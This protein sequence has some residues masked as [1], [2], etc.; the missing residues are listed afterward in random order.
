MKLLIKSKFFSTCLGVLAVF[1]GIGFILPLSNFSVYMT[2]NIYSKHDY[3]TMHYGFFISLIFTFAN[4]ISVTLG[5]YL[6]NLIGFYKTTTVGF[7]IAFI[8]NT[9][10]IFQQDIWFCYC[11]TLIVGTGAGVATSLLGKNVTLYLP[12]KKG[13]VSGIFGIGIMIISA[14]Y[15][16]SGEKLINFE[17]YTLEEDESFYPKRIAKNTYKYFLIGEF[18]I[19]IGLIFALLLLYEYKPEEVFDQKLEGE[20]QI[21]QEEKENVTKEEAKEEIK[22]EAKEEKKEEIKEETKEETEEERQLKMKIIKQKLKRVLKT[23]RFWKISL[24]SFFINISISFMVTTGRTFGALIGING[25]ALQF[26]GMAQV[27][28]TLII[29][30][31]L[32]ILVDKKGGLII[33]RITAIISILPPIFLAFFMQNTAIFI[34][35]FVFDVLVLVGVMVCFGP[36][37][38]DIYGIQESVLFGGFIN[39][40]SKIGDV[41]TTFGAFG[42]SLVCD[43]DKDCLKS[44]YQIMYFISALCCG[45]SCFLLFLER[46]DKYEY[47]IT[48]NEEDVLIDENKENEK[49]VINPNEGQAEE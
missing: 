49:L 21:S 47:N 35:C 38:M 33:L 20:K 46:G 11:L 25:T 2:S 37:I 31:I 36:F 17:G 16:L 12:D 1:L 18:L 22:E 45:I 43:E 14:I 27:L 41:I 3:V 32:G 42:F 10:F 13:I 4:T 9:C 48:S 7:I 29:G 6:E 34:I 28:A 40:F 19:P 39:G 5:G 23:F 8:A 44:R 15:A 26:A 30:P 24:I